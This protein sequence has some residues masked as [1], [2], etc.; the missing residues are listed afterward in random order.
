[1]NTLYAMV[2]GASEGLGKSFA[3]E[4]AAKGIPLVLVAL[5]NTG[6]PQLSSFILKNFAV[7]AVYFEMDL[8]DTDKYAALFKT[9]Q[10]QEIQVSILINNAGVGNW[11]WFDDKSAIFYKK[12]NRTEC[13]NTGTAYKSVF[14]TNQK[15]YTIVYTKRWQFRR[16][17]CYS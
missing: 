10:E 17:I 4:L 13:N 14:G 7:Q 5:P 11:G 9:L 16:D 6:L 1:M 8:T 12:A 2:T 15:R 3:I